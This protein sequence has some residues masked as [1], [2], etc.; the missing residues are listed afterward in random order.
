MPQ[1]PT[2]RRAQ[3]LDVVNLYRLVSGQGEFDLFNQSDVA[4]A[5]RQGLDVIEN[6]YALV[7]E[8]KAGRLVAALAFAGLRD[9]ENNLVVQCVG[10]AVA[11][12][13][14]ESSVTAEFLDMTVRAARAKRLPVLVP[15]LATPHPLTD[16]AVEYGFKAM[17][18]WLIW[19]HKKNKNVVRTTDRESG[20]EAGP[21][22]ERRV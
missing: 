12:P 17:D 18:N 7:A 2:I 10:F 16:A 3:P 8:N 1:Q 14:R 15:H 21:G 22:A 5:L 19:Q 13:Y 20:G 4:G 6:G 11:P 9:A